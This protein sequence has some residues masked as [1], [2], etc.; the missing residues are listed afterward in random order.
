[1]LNLENGTIVGSV[2]KLSRASHYEI[3]T[4][5]G[6]AGI[7]GT[8][9]AVSVEALPDG[10]YRVTFSCVQGEVIAAALVGVDA[11]PVT[12]VLNSG[13][14]WTP[15]GNVNQIAPELLQLYHDQIQ[16]MI[17]AIRNGIAPEPGGTPSAPPI[18]I[19]ISP[20]IPGTPGGPH[21]VTPPVNRGPQ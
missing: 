5:N 10:T 1:M 7:R 8:D 20:F 12:K 21:P 17:D 13:E 14:S 4:P 3:R 15:G 18:I 11:N 6:V 2:E 19:P 9:F 16:K